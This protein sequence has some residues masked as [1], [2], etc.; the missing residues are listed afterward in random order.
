MTP[1]PDFPMS[2]FAEASSHIPLF[3]F[4]F[5]GPSP[6]YEVDG[7]P[8]LAGIAALPLLLCNNAFH[9]ITVGAAWM[10][11]IALHRIA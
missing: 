4:L 6:A 11:R 8:R 7:Q 2:L 10:M 5:C 9:A 1:D 3:A